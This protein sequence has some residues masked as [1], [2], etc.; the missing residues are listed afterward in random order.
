M[1]V[2][3][4]AIGGGSSG[5]GLLVRALVGVLAVV[6]VVAASVVLLAQLR[7]TLSLSSPEVRAAQARQS[8]AETDQR[9]A[10]LQRDTASIHAQAAAEAGWQ[11]WVVGAQRMA[12][13]ALLLAVPALLALLA[14]A[15]VLF[16]RRHLSLPTADGR[17]PLV[18]LD[19]E[20]SR[21]ALANYQ[22]GVLTRGRATFEALPV[23]DHEAE[24]LRRWRA[25]G[26][27][28]EEREQGGDDR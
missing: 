8:V 21:E 3:A 16:L 27:T 2:R 13:V 14:V 22:R 9:T 11:P 19:R 24:A 28:T 23:S 6:V 4:E 20:L 5:A 25:P 1:R 26:E 10:E 7:E 17:V 18:G 12:V 15:G